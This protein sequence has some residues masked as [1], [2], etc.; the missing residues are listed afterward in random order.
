MASPI[1]FFPR[2]A[3]SE[4]LHAPTD[5]LIGKTLERYGL[6]EQFGD[7]KAASR[8]VAVWDT[9]TQ[10][11]PDKNASGAM[12]RAYTR[13]ADHSMLP[14]QRQGFFPE[15][16]T[17]TQVLAANETQLWIGLDNDE[18]PRPQDLRRAKLIPGYD[19]E[20]LDGNEWHVP[21]IRTPWDGTSL[22]A[23]MAYDANGQYA[24]PLLPQYQPAFDAF[25]A[26]TEWFMAGSFLLAN[27][28]RA[29]ELNLLALGLNYR[30]G[31][32]ESKV[33]RLVGTDNYLDCLGAA[34]DWPK[35]VELAATK[36]KS[37]PPSEDCGPEVTSTSPGPPGETPAT[38]IPGET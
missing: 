32:H 31:Q 14:G 5:R 7:V 2:L 13:Q 23:A 9:G 36:K 8:E 4:L 34:I 27:R 24:E 25:A 10:L 3:L 35:V 15:L 11:G 19:V 22:P 29:L 37:L 6:A 28:P 17:W 20:L 26:A 12:L 1:Y 16:Q 30:Y 18:P 38:A 21:V 33:L